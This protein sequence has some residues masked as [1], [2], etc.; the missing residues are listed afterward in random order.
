MLGRL[1][2]AAGDRGVH[3]REEADALPVEQIR[4]PAVEPLGGKGHVTHDPVALGL[5]HDPLSPDL[6]A[7]GGA[8]GPIDHQLERCRLGSGG[9]ATDLGS[10]QETRVRIDGSP[11]RGSRRVTLT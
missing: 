7:H 1:P 9:K 2:V 4:Q 10:G 8:I 11:A 6:G 3:Q 5:D